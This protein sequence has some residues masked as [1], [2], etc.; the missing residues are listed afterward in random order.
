MTQPETPDSTEDLYNETS[1]RWQRAQP[2][3]LSDFTGRPAVFEMCGD[4]SGK[5]ILDLGCGEGYCA[6]ILA[7]R[8]ASRIVGLE[9]SAEMIARGI[10]QE[11]AE[12]LGIEYHQ[13]DL[14]KG[15]GTTEQFDLAIAVFLF[16]YTTSEQMLDI[17]Q[18]TYER[19]VP[20]GR[21]V[22]SVPHPSFAFMSEVRYPFFFDVDDR[23]YFSGEDA[24]NKGQIFRRD[25]IPLEVQM[26]HR[27]MHRYFDALQSAGFTTMPVVRELGV[28]PE[29]LE[30]DPDFFGPLNDVPLHVAIGVT[31]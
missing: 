30:L 18:A 19:L 1:D 23:G 4:V 5:S 9:L 6:R 14:I 24:L 29:H 17:M 27:P 12:P 2:V 21:F 10:E 13:R 26:M 31:K 8:G 7:G 16:N 25:G 15:L 28:L 11:R 3:S 22:F 20:G